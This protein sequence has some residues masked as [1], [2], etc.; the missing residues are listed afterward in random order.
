[1]SS[2]EACAHENM[3]HDQ[4]E[5]NINCFQYIISVRFCIQVVLLF[6]DIVPILY[7]HRKKGKRRFIVA[8]ENIVVCENKQYTIQM[9]QI[10]SLSISTIF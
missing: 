3:I 1:M 10:Y 6:I 2:N 9:K 5:K 7:I 8:D 4:K